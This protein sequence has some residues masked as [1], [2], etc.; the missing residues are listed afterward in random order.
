MFDEAVRFEL[1][2][3]SVPRLKNTYFIH[4]NRIAGNEWKYKSVLNDLLPKMKL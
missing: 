1:E 2:V 3:C 4:T